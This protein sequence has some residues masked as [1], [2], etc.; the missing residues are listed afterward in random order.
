ML[1]KSDPHDPMIM[2]TVNKLI[3]NE[4]A[5]PK[6]ISIDSNRL[7]IRGFLLSLRGKYKLSLK[8]FDTLLAKDPN[9]PEALLFRA[10]V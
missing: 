9:H 7:L 4:Q 8:N 5:Q 10:I 3:K 1:I 6:S 2:E